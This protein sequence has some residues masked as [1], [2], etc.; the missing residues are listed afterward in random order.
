MEQRARNHRCPASRRSA[1]VRK[2]FVALVLV[3]AFAGPGS[4]AFG[5]KA[6][7]FAESFDIEVGGAP[8][9]ETISM[10]F[11]NAPLK[12]VL[13]LLSQQ[14]NLNLIASQDVELKK[15]TVYFD[16]VTVRDAFEAIVS[17]NGLSYSRKLN[18]NIYVVSA[19]RS[20]PVG[21]GT[22]IFRL[23]S[24]LAIEW[25]RVAISRP[26][27]STV[28]ASGGRNEAAEERFEIAPGRPR[29]LRRVGL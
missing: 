24:R 15:V 11:D 14:S 17:A 25:V 23:T 6:T 4:P 9:T 16:N 21:L 19:Q 22:K 28:P 10:S 5:A 20:E 7:D 12:D 13:M 26:S 2:R 18:S 27:S 29:H 1:A 8:S 3:L